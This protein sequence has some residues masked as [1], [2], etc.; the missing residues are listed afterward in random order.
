MGSI[1]I[2]KNGECFMCICVC[3]CVCGLALIKQIY[4][5]KVNAVYAQL[6]STEG[7][8]GGFAVSCVAAMKKAWIS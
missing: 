2:N 5:G 6:K 4:A 8:G 7:N 3:L 1:T